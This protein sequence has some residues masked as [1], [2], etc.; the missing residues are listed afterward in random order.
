MK[1]PTTES[2]VCK[3]D[4]HAITLR[5]SAG[6]FLDVSMTRLRRGRL[7]FLRLSRLSRFRLA[8]HE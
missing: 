4:R 6:H 5:R 3:R 2:A 7:N 8:V 1:V